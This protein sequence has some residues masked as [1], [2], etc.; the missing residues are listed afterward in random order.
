MVVSNEW[1]IENGEL[2]MKNSN[3]I[4]YIGKIYLKMLGLLT[5]EVKDI[6]IRSINANKKTI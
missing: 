4:F 5:F 2:T 1:K 6:E 3:I